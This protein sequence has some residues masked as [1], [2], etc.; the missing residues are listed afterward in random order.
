MLPIVPHLLEL[1]TLWL[2]LVSLVQL[3][4]VYGGDANKHKVECGT[5]WARPFLN[6]FS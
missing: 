6:E 2:P 1:H 4:E 5:Y 3:T